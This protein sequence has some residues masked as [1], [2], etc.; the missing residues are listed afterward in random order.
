MT[1]QRL[2]ACVP[3]C[4]SVPRFHEEPP[5]AVRCAAQPAKRTARRPHPAT[6]PA[7][8]ARGFRNKQS[9]KMTFNLRKQ[10]AKTNP[11][12]PS[13]PE[14]EGSARGGGAAMS[15]TCGLEWVVCLGCTRWAWKRLTYIGAYDSE[16]WPPASPDEFEPVP[17]LCRVVL[18]NYDPDLDN[19]KFAPP[20]RGYAD[21][22]PKGIV[23]RATYDDVGN[24]CP[25]YII[26]VDEAHKEVV[27]AVRG[28]NLVR[29]ADY[30]MFDGGYVHHGLLKAAQFILER[31]TETLRGLLRRYGPEYKLILTG[32]SLGSGIAA[33]MTVLVVNNRKEFDNIHRSRIKCYAL[34]PAR[35]M[36]LNL[37]VKYADVIN[38]VVLQDDFLPRTPTPLE[39]IFGSI[40]CSLAEAAKLKSAHALEHGFSQLRRIEGTSCILIY[41][42]NA[43]PVL[44][45]CRCGRFPPE[46]RTAIPVEGRFEH[47]VLSCSTTS[48]H[49]IAWIE[50]ESQK[51]LELMMESEHAMAP[52]PQQK[53]ERLKSFEEEHK[54]ALQRAKTLDVPHAA[55]LSEEEIQE[56]GSTAPT[57]DTHSETGMEPKSAGRTSWDK[58]ME[59][60]FTRDEDGKLVVKKDMAREIVVE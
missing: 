11:E 8:R 58:L 52:P 59:K 55:D 22:D 42:L 48:D 44:L 14:V 10:L 15:V 50:R 31:E 56:D 29:D 23:R 38:S 35:C 47:V 20:G 7:R 39:Y 41:C 36:S 2:R 34:A 49:A 25:P 46:V 26:Y 9:R 30:K 21:I 53:M 16:T 4:V 27:L 18:A 32:H 57:S 5:R 13:N 24:R 51:A 45:I 60:L 1:V 17:R 37:A 19:P 33:L 6:T 43:G 54:S 40:F 3:S 12:P 28:L